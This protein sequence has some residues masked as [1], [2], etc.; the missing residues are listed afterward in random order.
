MQTTISKYCGDPPKDRN[1][2]EHTKLTR[3]SLASVVYESIRNSLAEGE[4]SPNERLNIRSISQ[5]LGVSQTPVREALLQL[6]AERALTLNHNRSV[7]VPLL[8]AEQFGELRDIRIALESLA[9]QFAAQNV[10][11]KDIS[12]LAEI[13]AELISAKSKQDFKTTLQ[14][15][16]KFHFSTYKLSQREELVALIDALWVRTGPYL[17]LVYKYENTVPSPVHAHQL[18]LDAFARR[19]P[20]AAASAIKQDIVAGGAPI[21]EALKNAPEGA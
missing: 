1:M 15:N 5:Q 17:G 7:T 18:L 11:D 12:S 3:Y 16:R 13:H 8:S 21:L 4:L 2:T 19:D 14:L 9:V 6:I 20:D 10:S